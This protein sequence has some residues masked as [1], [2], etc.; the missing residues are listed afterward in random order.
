M[1]KKACF[2]II[3][4]LALFSAGCFSV[5]ETGVPGKV[6]VL[7]EKAG[8]KS[9]PA[10]GFI[11]LGERWPSE[12]TEVYASKTEKGVKFEIVCY[13]ETANLEWSE[14]KA[15]D[16][17]TLFN[18]EHVELLVAPYGVNEGGVYYHIA[19]NPAGSIYH[20]EK[21]DTSFTLSIQPQVEIKKNCW[22][23]SIEIP[24]MRI[25]ADPS[26]M[27]NVNICRTI[28]K[29]GASPEHSSWTG[30]SNF[31]D[32]YTMGQ[33]RFSGETQEEQLR[34]F[35]CRINRNSKLELEVAKT[36]KNHAY[37]QIFNNGKFS[38]V[39]KFSGTERQTFVFDLTN[40]Y[41]PLK[42]ECRISLY[43]LGPYR[44]PL[45]EF[46]GNLALCKTDFLTLDKMEYL[47][48]KTMKCKVL[49]FP[50]KAVIKD[51]TTTYLEQK[52]TGNET[53]LSL[54]NLKPGRYVLDYT[55]GDKRTSRVFFI[56]PETLPE[57][58]E[59]P[60][61]G[62][63]TV[64]N[65]DLLMD[66]KPF[67]LLG[68]SGGSKT[69]Y[70]V[71]AGFTLKY[72]DGARKNA[73]PYHG[74][75]GRRLVRKPV[76]GYAFQKNWENIIEKHLQNV[77]KAEKPAWRI[78]CYEANLA[79]LFTQEDGSLKVDP[80]GHN[81]YRKIYKMAKK[82]APDAVFSIQAD[83]LDVM[84]N[85][86]ESCDVLEYAIGSSSYHP[87]DM[88]KHF[89]RDFDKVRSIAGTKPLVPWLGG[90][91]PSPK[92]RTAEEIRA[93]VYYTILKGGA[94]NII[95]MG[96]GGMPQDRTRFWSMLSMLSREIE[97][98]YSDFKTWKETVFKVPEQLIGK[99][100]TGPN[101]ELL[102]VLL[103]TTNSEVKA[104]IEFPGFG[105]ETLTFTPYEPRV[106]RK[107]K[108]NS[109]TDDQ[110]KN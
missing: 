75:P 81:V 78:L 88:I 26:E 4:L 2:P 52:I 72:G 49:K 32:I 69:H 61:K 62:K 94:G 39:K 31:H 35:H 76:T 80:E 30:S 56:A 100:V 83:K 50:G 25:K 104:E 74:T 45:Q 5:K 84:Q 40:Q 58:V 20:A 91:I 27:W 37:L 60:E 53:E 9:Q 54:E 108:E 6:I 103:N 11:A 1:I 85:Y 43:L 106:I 46:N 23:A 70:P 86:I 87:T 28:K 57:V 12:Q 97:S 17:M 19:L 66:G 101:G 59:L 14:K 22:I 13:G 73:L 16:D 8:E 38:A 77:S 109:G 65:N 102:V 110:K 64:Q 51:D 33:L 105:R 93:G 41:V 24:H 44:V 18:G 92:N 98:F 47:N 89:G 71:P 3:S 36:G 34:I 107:Q 99:A 82:A 10:G 95:H 29:K 90:T 63:F 67:Y 55:S 7:P 21:R 42:G 48:A 68:I 96:H 79:V 15:D